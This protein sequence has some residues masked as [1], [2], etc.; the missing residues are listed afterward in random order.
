VERIA[1]SLVHDLANLLAGH[2]AIS[3]TWNEAGFER[4]LAMPLAAD[5]PNIRNS[6]LPRACNS[7]PGR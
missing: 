2:Q 6:L 4:L 5:R 7:L 1:A 3:R